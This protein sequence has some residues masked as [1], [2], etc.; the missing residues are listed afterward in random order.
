M[1]PG[2]GGGREGLGGKATD[3]TARATSSCPFVYV[4]LELPVKATGRPWLNTC[5]SREREPPANMKQTGIQQVSGRCENGK[6]VQKQHAG[7]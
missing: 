1:S 2:G 6:T 3:Q 7:L 4:S 5:K